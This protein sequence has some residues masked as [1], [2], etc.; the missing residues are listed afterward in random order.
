MK[1]KVSHHPL[2]SKSHIPRF[3]QLIVVTRG[4]DIA[5]KL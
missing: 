5:L 2:N 3:L 4:R 1:V